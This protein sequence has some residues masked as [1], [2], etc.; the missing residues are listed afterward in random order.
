MDLDLQQIFR[1][2]QPYRVVADL[3]LPLEERSGAFATAHPRLPGARLHLLNQELVSDQPDCPFLAGGIFDFLAWHF[4]GDYA[5]AGQYVVERYSNLAHHLVGRS[6]AHHLPQLVADLK[7]RR[8][9]FQAILNLKRALAAQAP[10]LMG[11]LFW[12]R[13]QGLAAE[14]LSR[15]LYLAPGEE[16]APIFQA[17][18][19]RLKLSPEALYVLYTYFSDYHTVACIRLH[20]LERPELVQTIPLCPASHAY[21]GLHTCLPGHLDY[22]V[23]GSERSALAGYATAQAAGHYQVGCLQV[24]LDPAASFSEF[25]LPSGT[26]LVSGSDSFNDLV[27][28]RSAF[29]NFQVAHDLGAVTA[30]AELR[31]VAWEQYVPQE[32]FRL[33]GH[34]REPTP[35]LVAFMDSLKTDRVMFERLT[36]HL[37]ASTQERAQLLLRLNQFMSQGATAIFG[38]I[39]IS[40]TAAGYRARRIK[41]G[42]EGVMF[43]NFVIKLDHNVCFES[44]LGVFHVGRL[45]INQTVYPLCLPH[46]A[47][48]H[49]NELVERAQ[50]AVIRHALPGAQ[51]VPM[52]TDSTFRNKLASLLQQQAAGLPKVSGVDRLGWNATRTQFGTP[53][54]R[55]DV[56]GRQPTSRIPYPNAEYLLQN[57][58]F[59]NYRLAEPALP[60]LPEVRYF[61]ALLV[62][63]LVRSYLKL[64]CPSVRVLRNSKSV[65][66]LHALFLPLGQTSPYEFNPNIRGQGPRPLLHG[67]FSGYPLF[68]YCSNPKVL[69]G[70]ELP[71]FLLSDQGLSF[72]AELPA[73]DYPQVCTFAH[74]LIQRVLLGLL[75]DGPKAHDLVLVDVPGVSDLA[76]EGK[77]AV[78]RYYPECDFSLFTA[79]LPRFKHLL[80]QIAFDE[81]PRYFKFDL[82]QQTVR[83]NFR[84]LKGHDRKEI[85]D[86]LQT[87]NP[88]VALQREHWLVAPAEFMLDLLSQ[89]YDQPVRLLAASGAEEAPLTE[90]AASSH[91]Q[92]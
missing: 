61:A 88:E 1:D 81:L 79:N 12:F 17:E 78:E 6:L 59:E 69:A 4:E 16:L 74:H 45:I 32:F 22:R 75:R 56:S 73:E 54:W 51:D 52:V 85:R 90:P 46:S 91:A 5:R 13:E 35:A 92:V 41:S 2:V 31:P 84:P 19:P 26:F 7:R 11:Q 29:H 83:L 82:A 33:L 25:K 8:E 77:R 50:A 39:Q 10:S 87:R 55:M 9:R 15:M 58:S 49:P 21:F 76:F 89:F 68:G 67:C 62:S 60:V 43:T 34:G 64:A 27:R 63:M 3:G 47:L 65:S 28:R 70:V 57:Y 36:R 40:E 30:L 71:L 44:D 24:R 20:S 66:L 14:H 38:D 18:H 48:A 23:Y 42:G 80:S 53:L 37:G 86:E 72:Q